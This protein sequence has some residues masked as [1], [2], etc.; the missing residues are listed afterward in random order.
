[1]GWT[2]VRSR[3][4]ATV[5]EVERDDGLDRALRVA[6]EDDDLRLPGRHRAAVA[7]GEHRVLRGLEERDRDEAAAGAERGERVVAAHDRG[8]AGDLRPSQRI[9]RMAAGSDSL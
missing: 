5:P 4:V 2:S 9:E 6:V 8:R 7:P 1:M 3:H